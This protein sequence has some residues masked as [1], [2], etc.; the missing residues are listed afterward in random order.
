MTPLFT[1]LFDDAALFPPG[2]APMDA[3]VPAHRALRNRLGAL[4]GPFVVP[5]ARLDELSAHLAAEGPA[6]GALLGVSVIAP[7]GDLPAAAALVDAAPGL[8]LAAV[9]V[10]VATDAA[11]VQ[12]AV[13]VLAEVVPPGTPAA[14]ELPRSPAREAVLDAL[15]GTGL[16]AKLRTGGLRPELI[17]SP[18]ELAATLAACVDRGIALKCTAGLHHA[19]RQLDTATGFEQHGLL[20]VLLAVGALTDGAPVAAATE[21]LRRTDAEDVVAALRGWTPERVARARATF[22]SFGTCSVLEPVDD[23]AALGLLQLPARTPA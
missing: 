21:Q 3:A 15:T 7:A 12:L 8:V 19:V 18:E 1:G 11:A 5:A 9:E 17:P 6:D 2:D 14:V 10:P 16:R 20:N 13:R 4:V 22:T 23:L